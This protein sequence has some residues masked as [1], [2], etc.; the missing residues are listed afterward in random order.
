MSLRDRLLRLLSGG[1][2]PERDPNEFVE[3]ATVPLSQAPVLVNGLVNAG[4]DA[5]LVETF[6]YPRSSLGDA[7]I[8][9]ARREAAAATEALDLLR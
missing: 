6:N 1:E 4:F 5:R 3:I 2:A 9:V 7:R 8:L